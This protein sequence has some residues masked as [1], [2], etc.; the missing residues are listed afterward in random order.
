[1]SA[2]T[3]RVW[4]VYVEDPAQPTE[5]VWLD[6]PEWFAW[7]ELP[8][9]RRFCYPVFDADVGYIVGFMTVRK[10]RRARGGQYWVAYRR[11]QGQLR[12]VYL[13]ASARL[14]RAVLEQQAQKF[15]AASKAPRRTES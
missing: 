12:R 8:T 4:T 11:C 7:L 1:M 3:P 15:L 2:K 13:G 10:E 9:T 5:Q 6:R 14:T